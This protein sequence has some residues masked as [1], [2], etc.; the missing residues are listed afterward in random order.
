MKYIITLILI[1][2][3]STANAQAL[4]SCCRKGTV[5]NDS[6]VYLNVIDFGA[7]PNDGKDDWPALQK[8]ADSVAKNNNAIAYYPAGAYVISDYINYTSENGAR[9]LPYSEVE[10]GV[11]ILMERRS[12]YLPYKVG[13]HTT[14]GQCRRCCPHY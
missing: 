2:T 5:L 8:V 10:V 7:A 11:S 9:V 13:N 1:I 3:T 14:R 6:A 4:T 12:M